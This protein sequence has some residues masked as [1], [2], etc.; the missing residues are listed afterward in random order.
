MLTK[1]QSPD[2]QGVGQFTYDADAQPVQPETLFDLASVSKVVGTTAMAMLLWQR[3]LL[4]L[5]RP[6]GETLP[7]FVREEAPGSPKQSV[8]PEVLL[9]HCSGLPAY[10]R[11]YERCSTRSSLL[12]A[13]LHMPLE[14]AP[15]SRAVYSD[16]GFI[17]LGQLLETLAE[18]P[19][20]T[21]CRREIFAPLGMTSTLYCP[22]PEMRSSIPPTG[23]DVGLRRGTVQGEVHDENCSRLG[24]VAGH[25]GL[26]S[27]VADVLG[28]ASC[29]LRGGAPVFQQEA[30]ALFTA[31]HSTPPHTS[32]ALGWD[33]PSERSSSGFF[34]SSHSVGHLGYT[35]TSLWIDLEKQ[36]AVALL[37]NRTYP[38]A[39]SERSSKG[40]RRVRPR[41]HDALMQEWNAS[42]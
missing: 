29:I 24:G 39:H 37:T 15:G 30:V 28:F 10:E 16:I 13:C 12:D 20:D 9:A 2:V 18:E 1:D 26:F 6:V 17:V 27:N 25:A 31:R 33:T 14:A 41:F 19:L 36:V 32:R 22:S 5:H 23:M 8:T 40:I 21:F 11:L 35:G 4:D 38:D 34:F 3:G 7:E 42:K